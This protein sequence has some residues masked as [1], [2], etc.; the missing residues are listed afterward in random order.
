MHG[1]LG[2]RATDP[3]T[4][5]TIYLASRRLNFSIRRC[6]VRGGV[7]RCRSSRAGAHQIPAP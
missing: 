4:N 1:L 7:Q 2:R 3:R 5:V 6:V